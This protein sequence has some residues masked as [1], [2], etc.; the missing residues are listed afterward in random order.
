M[1]LEVVFDVLALIARICCSVQSLDWF[2]RRGD[3]TDD[4]AEILFQSFLREAIVSSSG[5]GRDVHSLTLSIQYFLCRPRRRPPS[6]TP[7]RMVILSMSSWHSVKNQSS[8][9]LCPHG[10]A[11]TFYKPAELAHSFL[12]CSFVFFCLYGPFNCI[13]FHKFS[14]QLFAFSLCSS[15]LISVYPQWGAADAEIKVPSGENTE[16]KRSPFQAWSTSVYSHTCYA[17]CQGFLPCLFLPFQSIH[18]H[19][20]QNLSQFFP[21]LACRIK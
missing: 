18:L 9:H 10:L 7:W 11:L 12:F 8:F 16:L 19:F 20:F 14:Q 15:S 13:S 1:F 6:K 3:M 4:S 17:Y 21:V 5:M 2:G